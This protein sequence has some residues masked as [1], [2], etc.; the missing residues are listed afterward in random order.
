MNTQRLRECATVFL[1]VAGTLTW[2]AYTAG[3]TLPES[4]MPLFRWEL[5]WL[6]GDF[7]IDYL[8]LQEQHGETIVLMQAMLQEYRIVLGQLI[9]PGASINASTLALH[10][11]VHPILLF[12][13]LAAWPGI[14]LAQKP[15][16]LLIGF[17]FVLLAELMDIPVILWAT[18]EDMLY[19]QADPSMANPPVGSVIQH[20][21]DGGGR[22][23]ITILFSL[24]AV[25]IH[26]FVTAR[27]AAWFP[28]RRK[29]AAFEAASQHH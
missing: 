17:P 6:M 24:F 11:W 28:V 9:P 29:A 14:P 5:E 2:L 1:A 22:Y 19:W 8:N 4:L 16:L 27:T 15:L 13:L 23:G 26:R 3:D 21:L 7:R 12:S 18:I 10:A 25:F 20:A